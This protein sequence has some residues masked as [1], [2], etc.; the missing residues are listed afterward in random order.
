MRVDL[1]PARVRTNIVVFD[2]L[3]GVPDAATVVQLAQQQDVLIYAFGV[4]KLRVVTHL[5]VTRAQCLEAV[6]VLED[7]LE[8]AT[9]R[10]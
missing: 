3:P 7:L 8:P 1:D 5:D 4:R 10:S 6:A 2:L 9:S